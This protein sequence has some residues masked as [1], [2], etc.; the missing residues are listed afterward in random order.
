MARILNR[1]TLIAAVFDR[2]G[3]YVT[4]NEKAVQLR[5]KDETL[6]TSPESG[7][8]FKFPVDV[9]PENY[10]VRMVARDSEAQMMSAQNSAVEIP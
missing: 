5:S 10:L 6:E 8:L 3:N 4:G 7:L 2:N 9:A 1:I